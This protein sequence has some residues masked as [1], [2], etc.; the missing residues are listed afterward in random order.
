LTLVELEVNVGVTLGA[1]DVV[2]FPILISIEREM[3]GTAAV[4]ALMA[5]SAIE[6][7]LFSMAV[8]ADCNTGNAP[9]FTT[10][11]LVT[12]TDSTAVLVV[13]MTASPVVDAINSCRFRSP[14]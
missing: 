5:T 11:V 3:V 14:R 12:C 4:T 2:V 10:A 9:P 1:V 8:N 13:V 7:T 6:V